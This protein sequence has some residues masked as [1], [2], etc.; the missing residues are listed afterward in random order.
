M[1]AIQQNIREMLKIGPTQLGKREDLE[2]NIMNTSKRGE[3]EC[4]GASVGVVECLAQKEGVRECLGA[5]LLDEKERPDPTLVECPGEYT[6]STSI[7]GEVEC[8]GRRIT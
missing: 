6:K 2:E 7:W 3:G 4:S 5:T 1:I 8:P